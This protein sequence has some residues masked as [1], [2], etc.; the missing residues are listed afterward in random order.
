M[1][2]RL[3]VPFK[4]GPDEQRRKHLERELERMT[5]LFPVMGVKKAILFGSLARG[6]VTESSD[7]DLVIIKDSCKGFLDR[8]EEALVIL[9]PRVAL[10]VLVYTPKEFQELVE[11]TPFFQR[12][13]R[14]GRVVYEA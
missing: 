6:D 4:I 12:V 2:R 3:A 14:E 11:N 10:D 7:I 8:V 1:R 5:A 13:V 9:D